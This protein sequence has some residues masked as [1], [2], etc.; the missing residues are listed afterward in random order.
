M[1]E[2]GLG[3]R[4]Q[5]ARQAAGLTQQQLCQKANLSFSTLTKIERGAIKSPSIFT[6]QAIA[7]ALE[8]G[9]D[10]L[11]GMAATPVAG[12]NLLQTKSGVRFVYFDVNG[13]LVR[14]YQRAFA[15]IAEETGS[16]ADTV[17]TAHWHYTDD[18][19][20]GVMTL[21][22]FNV[23]MAKRLGVE[24][25]DWATFYLD[26]AE[27]VPGMPELLAWAIERYKIGLLTN[28]MPGL[29]K[30][31]QQ[32]GKVP[33]L[34]Y[35]AIINSS[36]VGT[37]KPEPKIFE[38][39]E[40]EAGVPP[41]QILLVDDTQGNLKVAEARGWKVLWFDYARPEESVENIRA[42]LEPAN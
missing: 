30:G 36:E 10:A 1:D 35:D 5:E 39:A 37:I 40:R 6:V 38:I 31:L 7:M 23:A 32:H 14:F 28:I 27:A 33:S 21:D 9:L 18:A 22:D 25:I 41:E 4:L 8:T 12:R 16:T 19:C 3:K 15:R 24:S 13:C 26:T 11:M 17:E 2:K 29:L 20:R 42:A 34:P